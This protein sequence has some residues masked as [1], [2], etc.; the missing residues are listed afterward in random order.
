MLNKFVKIGAAAKLLGVS[1]D[2]LRKWEKTGELLP[3]RKSKGGTR[4]EVK[5]AQKADGKVTGGGR[6]N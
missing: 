6:Q 3:D 2:T 4:F 5:E 1:I